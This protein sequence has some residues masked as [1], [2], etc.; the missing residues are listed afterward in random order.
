MSLLTGIGA[1]ALFGAA[2]LAEAQTCVA[3]PTGMVGWWTGNGTAA[4]TVLGNDGQLFGDATFATGAVGQGF[5]LDGVGDYI[6]IPDSLDLKP[7]RVSV[8]AWV[9]LDSLT[10]SQGFP[11]MQYIVFKKNTRVFNHEAY[12]LRKQINSGVHNFAFSIGDVTG[13][14]TLAVALSTTPI[15]VGQFY[16]LVGT[17]D[18]QHVRLYVNGAL[19]GQA[20]VSAT[21]DYGTRPIFIGTSGESFDGKVNGIVDE[22]TIYN[23]ALDAVDVAML[24]SAGSAGKCASPTALLSGLA[25]FVQNLNLSAGISNSLDSKL[26]TALEALDDAKAGNIV[27]VCN[28]LQAFRNEVAAQSG[29]SLTADQAAQ[30]STMA[31][32][33]RST[34]GCQ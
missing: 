5:R 30:L 24:Y 7:P 4:D 32:N 28:R 29:I 13:A 33:I 8:E 1:A 26:R 20:A 16:H 18:G 2:S 15:V 9:R 23:R 22:A 27:S 6:E 21:I 3:P 25:Q 14:A 19:E 17:Y 31:A 12:A 34:M 11:G 10:T